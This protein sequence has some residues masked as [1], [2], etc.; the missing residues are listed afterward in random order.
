MYIINQ[1]ISVSYQANHNKD[2]IGDL[3]LTVIDPNDNIL[4]TV[5]Y[6]NLGNGIYSANFIPNLKGT[7]ITK[8]CSDTFQYDTKIETFEVSQIS[9]KN[10]ISRT[11][12]VNTDETVF[13][14]GSIYTEFTIIV[15]GTKNIIIK[16]NDINNDEIPLNGGQNIRDVIGSDSLEINKIYHRTTQSGDE[17]QILLWAIK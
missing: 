13:D 12:N 3:I 15:T 4:I 9:K 8:T 10:Y 16:L 17:S 2:N 1:Q 14:L 6:T 11:I 5:N 7:W